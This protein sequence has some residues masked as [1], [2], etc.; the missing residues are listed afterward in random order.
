MGAVTYPDPAVKKFLDAKFVAVQVHT[1]DQADVADELA[2][3]W[4]PALIVLDAEGRQ[5][6]RAFGY[7]GPK[8]LI[9]ELSLAELQA[10]IDAGDHAKA[11]GLAV[12]TL[13]ACRGDAEREPEARYFAGVAAYKA[14][15]RVP[16]LLKAWNELIDAF[17]QS[18][19]AKKVSFIRDE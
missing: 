6:R 3:G 18:A 14:S 11:D 13:E 5:H 9:A 15:G 19:W 4:T 16:K 10:A 1:E 8:E 12:S 17:P 7:H 2:A